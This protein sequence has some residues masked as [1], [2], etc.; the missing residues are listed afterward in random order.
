[1]EI[2]ILTLTGEN[3]INQITVDLSETR[4]RIFNYS[5]SL[6][7]FFFFLFFFTIGQETRLI[8]LYLFI[9]YSIKKLSSS[10]YCV[11]QNKTKKKVVNWPVCFF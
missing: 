2:C 7:L 5:I 1:M 8:V 4:A 11:F 10:F 9:S 3:Q 6:S